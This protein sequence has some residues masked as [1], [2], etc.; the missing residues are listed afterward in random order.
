[1]KICHY[2]DVAAEIS[3]ALLAVGIV[4]TSAVS[5]ILV[6]LTAGFF[7]MTVMGTACLV[8]CLAG[9]GE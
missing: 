2:L 1:V 9:C 5:A 4:A 8:R 3:A 6:G 7:A